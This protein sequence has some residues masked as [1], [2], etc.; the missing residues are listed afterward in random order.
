M[1]FEIRRGAPD[2]A[3][4]IAAVWAVATPYLVK[5]AAGIEAST[6]TKDL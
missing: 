4:G 3:G 2:D 5:T 1:P 6:A